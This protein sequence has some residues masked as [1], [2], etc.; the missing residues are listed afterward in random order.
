MSNPRGRLGDAVP[1]QRTV[2]GAEEYAIQNPLEW[3]GSSIHLLSMAPEA[4]V[5]A[6]TPPAEH[7]N[8]TG[9]PTAV[10][11]AESPTGYFKGVGEPEKIECRIQFAYETNNTEAIT[12]GV[13]N[14]NRRPY[15]ARQSWAR[16]TVLRQREPVNTAI[17]A[18]LTGKLADA[19]WDW[20]HGL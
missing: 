12:P 5:A 11:S 1:G 7:K 9:T 16:S 6:M 2:T 19:R 13:L 4:F 14:S 3:I 10:V 8:L 15:S 17:A 20:P 18:Y